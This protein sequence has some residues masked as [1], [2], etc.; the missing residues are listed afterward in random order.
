ML[1]TGTR[2]SVMKAD[3]SIEPLAS[4]RRPAAPERSFKRTDR[5]IA[6]IQVLT[7]SFIFILPF[8]SAE[9]HRLFDKGFVCVTPGPLLKNPEGAE[10]LLGGD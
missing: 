9:E 5:T 8:A 4:Q 7:L 1:P 3:S 6:F 2:L 10:E